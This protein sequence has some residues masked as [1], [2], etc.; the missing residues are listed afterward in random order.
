M[1]HL[2]GACERADS[3][4][5]PGGTGSGTCTTVVAASPALSSRPY[6]EAMDSQPK[7]GGVTIGVDIGGTKIAAGVVNAEGAILR[8]ARRPTPRHDAGA[9]LG[10]VAAVVDELH[11]EVDGSIVGVGVGVAGGVDQSRSTVY[12][13]PNLAWSQVP[14]RAVLEA[15][16]GL[17]VVVENDGAAAAWAETRF[18][19]GKGLAHVVMVTVGTGIGGGIVVDGQVMRGA[20]GVAA[21][22]GHLNAVPDGRPCG[23]G[24]NGC[25]EQY[26]SGNALVRE[27]RSLAAERRS[28][29]GTLLSLGDGT[30]EGVEGSHITRA[31]QMGDPVAIEAF[32]VAGNWLGR[33]LADLTAIVDPDA[34]VIGGGVSEAGDL[35][36]A[37]AQRT[38]SDKVFG[39]TN[40]PMPKLLVAELG[41]DAGIVGAA[42]LA[43]IS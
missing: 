28:E 25:W 10:E 36:L 24:R 16:T 8:T 20:H 4:P 15:S 30:P 26:A 22:I 9:V 14:V 18:G 13:A 32:A 33:G 3:Y 34:F 39:G 43:R 11:S 38:L 29:A 12:F 2:P 40:R 41:N 17:P 27:A 23:C 1:H 5:S 7:T 42:D 35:L 19:A 37:S 6:I 31:A 21:E